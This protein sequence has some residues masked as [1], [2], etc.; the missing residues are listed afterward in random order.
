[1]TDENKPDSVDPEAGLV[2]EDDELDLSD[3]PE[4]A[5]EPATE[6]ETEPVVEPEPEPEPEPDPEPEPEPIVIPAHAVSDDWEPP[7]DRGAAAETAEKK[8]RRRW[9]RYVLLAVLVLIGAAYVAGYFLTGTRMPASASIGGV[10]VSG[11]SPAEARKA[12]DAALTPH[13]DREIVLTHGKKEFT[14]KPSDAGLALDVERSVAQ[15]GGDRSWDPRDMA[16][17]FFGDHDEAPALDV[18]DAALRS[19]IDAI[20]ESVNREVVE[21]QISFPDGKPKPREPKPGR[22]VPHADAE[23]AIRAAYLVSDEPIEVPMV[24]VEPTVDSEGLAAAM[25]T[26]AEPAV[27][28]PVTLVV[29]EKSVELPVSAYAPALT[30]RVKD[31]VLAPHLDPEKLAK[32]LTDSTTGIGK[33]AVDATIEI[34]GGK[35]VVIPGKEGIGLQPEEMATQL[36]PA[37]TQTGAARTVTVE[38]KVVAPSFTTE[39]AKALGITEK[40]GDFTTYFPYAEYRNINQ[41]R[42]AELIDGVIVKPGETFSFNDTVGERTEANGFTTGTVINGGVFREELGGGVSQ[43]VTTMYNATFFGGMDDV[44]HH[45][46]AFYID[47]YPMGR[48]ATVYYGS[49]D[50]RW[51]NPTDYGVLVRAYVKKSTPSSRGEMHVELWSTKVWDKIE[52]GASP[53]RN[54]RSP[55]TQYDD[56]PQCVPQGPIEGFDIDIYRT[57]YKD[58][59]KAKSE[60]KTANYQAADRVICSKKPKPK[61][62][63]D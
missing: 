41:S 17:L 50:L 11:K 18:D 23:A 2:V 6:R 49:L 58:G 45:P 20:G 26:I 42:G 36:I 4:T 60:T 38:A 57:F 43:V 3:E 54:G 22:I 61:K 63:D 13:V 10:D 46:H 14:I 31:G 53:K 34:K 40:I 24:D 5:A 56:T 27:S 33:K 47:R 52:A 44:E 29:G 7:S 8:P 15:V 62:S 28:G 48:E 9:G 19:A 39:D 37:L 55:G 51:K 30:V 12:V 35:P 59:K 16:G 25:T 32:P 21:A 1:M